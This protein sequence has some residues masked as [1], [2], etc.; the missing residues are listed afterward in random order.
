MAQMHR[1]TPFLATND[2]DATIAFYTRVLGFEIKAQEPDGR[3]T[4]VLMDNGDASII[5]DSKLWPGPPRMSGQVHF[6]F[7]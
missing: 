6:D 3:P 1:A 7:G 2:M 4:F 5:F